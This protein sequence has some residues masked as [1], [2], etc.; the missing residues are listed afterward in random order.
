[1]LRVGVLTGGSLLSQTLSRF[2]VQLTCSVSEREA[3]LNILLLLG[4]RSIRSATARPGPYLLHLGFGLEVADEGASGG[5]DSVIH[6]LDLLIE[7]VLE[8][9]VGFWLG[10][11]G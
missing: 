2:L 6:T 4:S 10:H 7:H 11:E 8:V 3:A 9:L 5:C 1:M